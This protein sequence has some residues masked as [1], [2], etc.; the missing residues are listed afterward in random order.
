MAWQENSSGWE[1][2]LAI[3][4]SDNVPD[5]L[6]GSAFPF[7][8]EFDNLPGS[9]RHPDVAIHGNQLHV[10]W[11]NSGDG[12]VKCLRGTL[13]DPSHLQPTSEAPTGA[14]LLRQG[15]GHILLQGATPHSTYRILSATGAVLHEAPATLPAGHPS[16][17][18]HTSH[19]QCSLFRPKRQRGHA[20]I[21]EERLRG[22]SHKRSHPPRTKN[23]NV[24][25]PAT[26]VSLVKFGG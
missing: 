11:Q 5:G 3:A 9:N 20:T 12:T 17:T 6:I 16:A 25:T 13:G 18:P 24:P 23:K 7:T 26:P 4:A 19:P 21:F 2:H 8:S 14:Q 22:L 10:I 15:T 1:I